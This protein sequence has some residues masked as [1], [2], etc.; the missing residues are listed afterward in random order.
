MPRPS[1]ASSPLPTADSPSRRPS[2][3]R[4]RPAPRGLA[5]ARDRVRSR[6]VRAGGRIVWTKRAARPSKLS[7]PSPEQGLGR[8]LSRPGAGMGEQASRRPSGHG[9][10]GTFHSGESE[11]EREA[12]RH[13]GAAEPSCEPNPLPDR[14]SVVLM[15]RHP[16]DGRHPRAGARP[17]RRQNCSGWRVSSSEAE[18]HQRR[19]PRGPNQPTAT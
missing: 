11:A 6:S 4:C 13:G 18:S 8:L 2:L 9:S 19:R 17:D 16:E 15:G 7:H 1:P 14:R 12:G 10:P 3:A 5:P